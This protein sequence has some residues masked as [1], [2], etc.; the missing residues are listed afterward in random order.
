M[1]RNISASILDF[2]AQRRN[3]VVTVTEMMHELKLDKRQIQG[4]ITHI[5]KRTSVTIETVIAGQA[6]MLKDGP[7]ESAKSNGRMMFEE[8]GPSKAGV[9]VLQNTDG[10][11]YKAEEL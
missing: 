11:L 8:I 4:N 1:T 7:Q 3:Q 6:W 5:R 9:L 2:L 10:K